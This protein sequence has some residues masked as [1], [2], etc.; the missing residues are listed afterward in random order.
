MIE[1][2][3]LSEERI[4]FC[5]PASLFFNRDAFSIVIDLK[6]FR[7]I[8]ICYYSNSLCKIVLPISVEHK[9]KRHESLSF[10]QV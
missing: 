2:L 9:E 5:Y 1:R 7:K 6:Y 10:T 3:V 8:V 4:L